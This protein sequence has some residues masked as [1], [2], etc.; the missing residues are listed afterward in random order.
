VLARNT[1]HHR[2]A[3][4]PERLIFRTLRDDN[5]RLLSLIT[6]G[7]DIMQNAVPPVL[8]GS[9]RGDGRIAVQ[10]SPSSIYT[11]IGFNLEDPILRDPAVRK[12]VATAIDRDALISR[13]LMGMAVKA[14][15]ILPPGHWA[16]EGDVERH[17]FDPEAAKT[18][19]D[20]AG[21]P[22]P[23]GPGPSKRFALIYKTS[24]NKFRMSVAR[25][26]AAYLEDVGIG[27]EVRPYEFG[28]FFQ[29]IKSGNF[30]MFSMQW[31]DVFE[32]DIF[33][34]VFHSKSIPASAGGGESA[35]GANRGRYR[36]TEL[37]A[38]LDAG[39]TEQDQAGRREIYS[40]VQKILARDLPY[41]SLWHEDNVIVARLGVSG[42]W[43][44]R[45]A[46]FDGLA[47][48]SKR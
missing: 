21:Y 18:M 14:A 36:N 48:V 46:D 17:P 31:T 22:D 44:N 38:L 8:A 12:A 25:A 43:T 16:Y 32:P 11:Y 23:D 3:P 39:R 6:G 28:T 5:T 42:Y 41:V 40:K 20:R 2:G 47:A 37:D 33:R 1:G 10:S 7:A 24:T 15:G 35:T 4:V 19:L 13:K 45:N 26:V 29:D 9:L 27:V 30:Q 34:Y